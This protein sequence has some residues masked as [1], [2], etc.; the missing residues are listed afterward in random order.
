MMKAQVRE[1]D[2]HRVTLHVCGRLAAEGWV[3]ELAKCWD[4]A[5]LKYHGRP[6]VVDLRDVT[7]IDHAGERL[8]ESMHRSGA[9]FLAAGLLTQEVVNKITGGAK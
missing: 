7:F 9:T 4:A 5:L 1:S 3:G 2:D 6:I 8:L